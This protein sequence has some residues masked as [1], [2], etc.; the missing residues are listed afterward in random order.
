MS[1]SIGMILIS[2]IFL[3]SISLDMNEML[4]KSEIKKRINVK[5]KNER[6]LERKMKR[7]KVEEESLRDSPATFQEWVKISRGLR[8]IE[9]ELEKIE[10]KRKEEINRLNR[11]NNGNDILINKKKDDDDNNDNN[12]NN[13][14]NTNI[15]NNNNIKIMNISIPTNINGLLSKR[16]II[17]PIIIT[18]ITLIIDELCWKNIIAVYP[19]YWINNIPIISY[20]SS[21][22]PGFGYPLGSISIIGWYLISHKV[23]KSL[24]DIYFDHQVLRAVV[25][26]E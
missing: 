1:E 4:N 23:I 17:F 14:T 8:E 22:P 11:M 25:E 3:I 20:M 18:I 16:W 7:M 26:S 19:L 5:G 10:D 24:F 21:F 13:N 12:D 6:N 2:I 9:K 15:N